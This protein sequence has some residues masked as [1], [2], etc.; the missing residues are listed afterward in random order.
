MLVKESIYD[1]QWIGEFSDQEKM[2][3]LEYAKS[4]DDIDASLR[5]G[6]SATSAKTWGRI[7][8]ERPEARAELMVIKET[9]GGEPGTINLDAL[10]NEFEIIAKASIVDFID[11]L[12]GNV[13]EPTEMDPVK[14]RAIK[15]IKRTVNPK[16]GHVTTVITMHDKIQALTNL[17]RIGG[18]YAADNGQQQGDV[19]IQINLPGGLAAL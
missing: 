10:V 19:N 7:F 14:A 15:E 11:P 1:R 6:R 9:S 8:L 16:N 5:A 17:G 3:L 13:M 4:G 12:T 2:F 18:H